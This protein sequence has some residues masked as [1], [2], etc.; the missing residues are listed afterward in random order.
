MGRV[1]VKTETVTENV[2][3]EILEERRTSE[4]FTIP[5]EPPYVKMYLNTVL[6]LKDLPKGYNPILLSLLKLIPWANQRQT[7]AINRSLKQELAKEIGCSVTRI[8][9]A[10]TDFVKGKILTRN[11]V[12]LY[13]FNPHLFGRGEW[14]DIEELR[15]TVTFDAKGKTVMGEIRHKPPELRIIE[16]EKTGTE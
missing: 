4:T 2:N 8:D 3:G 12:G 10:L 1:T 5:T 14:R 15:L 7:I 16:G 13:S 6:Y 11:N 9:H